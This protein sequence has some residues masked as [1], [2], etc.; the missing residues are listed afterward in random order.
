MIDPN[1][2]S[3]AAPL[4]GLRVVEIAESIAG[5]FEGRLLAELGA[6]VLKVERPGGSPTRQVGPFAGGDADPDRSLNFWTYNSSKQSVL[7][8]YAGAE[9]M[10]GLMALLHGADMLLTTHPPAALARIGLSLDALS[11]R[12]PRLIILSITPF[13]LTGPWADYASSEL[14]AMALGG[15][16]NSCGYDDHSIPPINPGGPQAS[17]CAT[18]FASIGVMLALVERQAS[19]RGQI[20]DIST[21]DATAMNIENANPFW[22]YPRV[23]VQRQTCRHAQPAPTQPAHF[24]CAD[25][26]Y[27]YYTLILSEQKAWKALVAW[28]DGHGVAAHLTDPAFL[29]LDHRQ[30][31]FDEIQS[32]TECFFLLMTAEEAYREGQ[33]AGLP[34]GM[35]NAP[36]DLFDD[37]HLKARGFFQTVEHPGVGAVRYPGPIYRF[38]AFPT[39]ARR[40]APALGAD[41]AALAD[42][43]R[44]AS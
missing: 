43:W 33:R 7:L 22:F 12:F 24:L 41:Q 44:P 5:E 39:E 14:V 1:P 19:G 8:D 27:V 23:A 37:P 38:S 10:D 13:G 42:P 34:I 4:D 28:M 26:R 35:V 3:G 30:A 21:H 32:I 17:H 40:A 2:A 25:G 15:P 20:I 36:E 9:G 11:E 18:S 31:H 29:D 6:R 16:L